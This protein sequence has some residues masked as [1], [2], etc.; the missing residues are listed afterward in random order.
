MVQPCRLVRVSR[1]ARCR[2]LLSTVAKLADI[3]V[4]KP[5]FEA[6]LSQPAG[7]GL[8]RWWDRAAAHSIR[9]VAESRTIDSELRVAALRCAHSLLRTSWPTMCQ[10]FPSLS[11]YLP[12][13]SG[14]PSPGGTRLCTRLSRS[15]CCRSSH[16]LQLPHR[17]RPCS[18]KHCVFGVV[19]RMLAQARD[20]MLR[21]AAIDCLAV[22]AGLGTDTQ[23][24][25]AYPVAVAKLG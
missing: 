7:Q 4:A 2:S 14:Q 8:V 25:C 10:L 11:Q 22:L 12:Q 16:L 18:T 6:L 17:Y 9:V 1:C 15:P 5:K 21:S 13:A 19:M 3:H 24:R 20:M 23:G